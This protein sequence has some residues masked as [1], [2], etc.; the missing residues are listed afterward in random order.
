M[1][2]NKK[3]LVL[4]QSYQPVSVTTVKKAINLLWRDKVDL[5]EFSDYVLRSPSNTIQSPLVIRLKSKINYNPFGRVELNRRN[6]FKRDG[7][8]CVYCGSKNDLTV[9]HIVPKSRG[10]GNS[11]ENLVTACR[12]C[13]NTK[14]DRTPDEAGLVLGVKPK[15]PFHLTFLTQSM[16]PHEKWKPYLFMT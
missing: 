12:P 15:K 4:N 14:D 3:V 7:H 1:G 16:T 8:T 5:V 2:V 13:N 10:G 6:I 9:D 11:W